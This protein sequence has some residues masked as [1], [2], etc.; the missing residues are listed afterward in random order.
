MYLT[1]NILTKQIQTVLFS[2]CP[3]YC[4]T[5]V[6]AFW[7]YSYNNPDHFESGVTPQITC[8]L[9][10]KHHHLSESTTSIY[11]EKLSVYSPEAKLSLCLGLVV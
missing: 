4:L 2:V 6:A 3:Y 11:S 8:L 1:H 7:N 10:Q 9:V 5:I